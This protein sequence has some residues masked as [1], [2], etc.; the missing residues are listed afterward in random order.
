ML[1]VQLARDSIIELDYIFTGMP[2]AA[3]FPVYCPVQ[4]GNSFSDERHCP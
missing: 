1:L 3:Q 4:P 2:K